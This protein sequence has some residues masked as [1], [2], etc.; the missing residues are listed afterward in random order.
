MQQ[1]DIKHFRMP[2]PKSRVRRSLLRALSALAS[3]PRDRWE[4]LSAT[5]VHDAGGFS[6]T[7]RI[8][9]VAGPRAIF[10][11]PKTPPQCRG[12]AGN[13]ACARVAKKRHVSEAKYE[14]PLLGAT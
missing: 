6:Q 1:V 3:S 10:R 5:R 14:A 7:H 12:M 11:L 13:E 8:R 2:T 4:E 9:D